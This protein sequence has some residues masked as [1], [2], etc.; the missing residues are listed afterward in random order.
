MF[1][2]IVSK[3]MLDKEVYQMFW[4]PTYKQRGNALSKNAQCPMGACG[5]CRIP[6]GDP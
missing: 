6:Q 2:L 1:D 4:V 5:L 3:E